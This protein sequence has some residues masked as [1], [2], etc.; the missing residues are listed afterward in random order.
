MGGQAGDDDLGLIIGMAYPMRANASARARS[1]N[2]PD[3][4]TISHA[5]QRSFDP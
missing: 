1:D 5:Q 2:K 4:D 3:E